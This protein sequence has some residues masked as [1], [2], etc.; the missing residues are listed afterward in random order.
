VLAV[1]WSAVRARA[2]AVVM[3]LLVAFTVIG[4]GAAGRAATRATADATAARIAAAAPAQRLVAVRGTITLGADPDEALARFRA[5][6]VASAGLPVER[7][8]TGWRPWPRR[9]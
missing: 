6:T 9:C 7:D 5:T 8:A 3:A 1:I 4:L 2:P